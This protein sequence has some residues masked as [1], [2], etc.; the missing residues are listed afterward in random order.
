V[1]GLGND[2]H[3]G[4]IWDVH[5]RCLTVWRYELQ[6]GIECFPKLHGH[7]DGSQWFFG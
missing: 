2:A 7:F 1:H 5:C 4:D 6:R 3:P